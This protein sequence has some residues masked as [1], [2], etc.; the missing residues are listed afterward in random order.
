MQG[1]PG[2][3]LRVVARGGEEA[4]AHPC[5]GGR[6]VRAR[7]VEHARLL[8][9][10]SPRHAVEMRDALEE[11]RELL[12]VGLVVV[13]ELQHLLRAEAGVDRLPLDEFLPAREDRGEQLER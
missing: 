2:R 13:D 12:Q 7:E 9:H 6:Q 11:E 10:G 1:V 4:R 3:E 5:L 8:P